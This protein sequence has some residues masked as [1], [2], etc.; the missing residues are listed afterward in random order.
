MSR[1]S[2]F[3]QRGS[4]MD[5]LSFLKMVL[6]DPIHIEKPSLNQHCRLL[7][8]DQ[9][10]SFCKQALDKRFNGKAVLFLESLLERCLGKQMAMKLPSVYGDHFDRI[11][12]MDSTEFKLPQAL[13]SDF[14]GFAGDGPV[15]CMQ[16]QFEYDILSSKIMDFS[17]RGARLSDQSY[18]HPLLEENV[19]PKDLI[20]R[21]LGYYK[22]ESFKMIEERGGYYIS[23]L[24][25]TTKIYDAQ[26]TLLDH[27]TLYHRLKRSGNK[28]LD[29]PIY[30][31]KGAK[32]PVRL[33]VTLLPAKAV[34]R[35]REK[36]RYKQNAHPEIYNYLQYMNLFITNVPDTMLPASQIVDLYRVRWQIELM[37]KNWKSILKIDKVR[38]MKAD[39]V[40]C[41]LLG[42]FLWILLNWEMYALFNLHCLA[43]KGEF[44]STYKFYGIVKDY[45]HVLQEYILRHRKMLHDWLRSL[46]DEVWRFGAKDET[47]G[48]NLIKLLGIR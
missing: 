22:T 7:L 38:K 14:P 47:P 28:S 3:C 12:L 10:K 9:G 18:A 23:R 2:G 35:R 41:Y 44:L 6:F 8:R 31:G 17:M 29:V 48:E 26:E 34:K 43:T 30:L 13:A 33:V 5:E 20:I 42:K 1:Q 37:F 32:H 27:K 4:K 21:D 40:R 11:R 36:K 45:V 25:P 39:R 16:I 15:A 19:R 46:F 24:H